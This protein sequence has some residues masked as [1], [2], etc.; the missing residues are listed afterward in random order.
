MECN[1][2]RE[3]LDEKG[4]KRTRFAEKFDKSF[5]MVNVY[6]CNRKQ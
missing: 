5:I 6:V 1:R 4:I 2:V 3:I